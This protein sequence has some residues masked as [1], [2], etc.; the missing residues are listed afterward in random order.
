MQCWGAKHF[1]LTDAVGDIPVVGRGKTFLVNSVA[2]FADFLFHLVNVHHH[3][4]FLLEYRPFA[5]GCCFRNLDLIDF[6][7]A[8]SYKFI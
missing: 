5:A 2:D 3:S 8:L 1:I 7:L 6:L 4:D